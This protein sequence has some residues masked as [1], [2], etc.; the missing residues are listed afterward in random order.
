MKRTCGVLQVLLKM[1]GFFYM[2][3]YASLVIAKMMTKPRVPNIDTLEQL[4]GISFPLTFLD[5]T[6]AT[7][8]TF[9]FPV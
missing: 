5:L 6:V 1:I 4:S 8:Y 7:V 9:S 3:M 2:T